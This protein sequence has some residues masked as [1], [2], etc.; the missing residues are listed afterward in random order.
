MNA[1]VIRFVLLNE[2]VAAVATGR[3]VGVRRTQGD[4]PATTVA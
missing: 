4:T 1:E 3:P 2:R